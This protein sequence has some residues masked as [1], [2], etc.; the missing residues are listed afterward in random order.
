MG[1]RGNIGKGKKGKGSGEK[2]CVGCMNI[3]GTKKEIMEIY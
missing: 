3:F 2:G 1:V